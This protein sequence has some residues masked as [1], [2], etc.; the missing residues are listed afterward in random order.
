MAMIAA[1]TNA[2]AENPAEAASSPALLQDVTSA[3]QQLAQAKNSLQLAGAPLQVIPLPSHQAHKRGLSAPAPSSVVL[4]S[5]ADAVASAGDA[6]GSATSDD[7]TSTIAIPA[8]EVAKVVVEY[9]VPGARETHEMA[10]VGENMLLVSQQSNSTLLK[11]LLSPTTGRPL[12]CARFLLDNFW[13]GLHGLY[14]SQIYPGHVWASLQFK[15][16]IIRIEPGLT[17][18]TTPIVW[19]TITLPSTVYGPHCV[20]ECG[21]DVWTG[22]KDS[23]HIVRI[24][25]ADGNDFTVFPCSGRPIFMARH[26][27]TQ[28]MYV[29]L[30]SSSKI[31]HLDVATGNTQEIDVP[32]AYG[33]TPVGM[34]AGTDGNVWFT[35]LGDASGGIGTFARILP[36]AQFQLFTLT[37]PIASNAGLIHLAFDWYEHFNSGSAFS[38]DSSNLHRL[39]LLSSTLV[40]DTGKSLDAVFSVL[41]DSELGRITT[42][43]SIVLPT[44]RCFTHRVLPHRTGLFVSQLEVSSLAHITGAAAFDLENMPGETTDFYGHFGNGESHGAFTYELEL[45]K[46][47][48]IAFRMAPCPILHPRAGAKL[49][50][51]L[52]EAN[53]ASTCA[54]KVEAT[55]TTT[56]VETTSVRAS[57][58]ARAT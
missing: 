48:R 43:Q 53:K 55:C 10:V 52:G 50:L 37:T 47:Q 51:I 17:L 1:G 19:Q 15:S 49:A 57:K 5:A 13:A 25:H 3:S 24:N 28:D 38:T 12:A 54:T 4:S 23:C 56:K 2:I 35:M 26:P 9:P 34:V 31:W 40:A 27:T 14:T 45:P 6:N 41:I 7:L 46:R 44:Q 30:D 58:R 32:A 18:S 8:V 16:L 36:N 22:C 20:C 33:N 21:P 42:Q 29:T 11:V 39:W